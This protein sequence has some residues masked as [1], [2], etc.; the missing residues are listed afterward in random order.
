M[1]TIKVALPAKLKLEAQKYI[2]SGWFADEGDL[3]RTALE[4]YIRHHRFQLMERFMKEDIDWALKV[5]AGAR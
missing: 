5:R 3:L 2:K 4:E 1:K